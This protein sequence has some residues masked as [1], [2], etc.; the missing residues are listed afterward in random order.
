MRL[1]EPAAVILV[2]LGLVGLPTA[3]LG[4]E[5]LR[6]NSHDGQVINLAGE[7]GAWSQDTIRV[8]QGQKLRLRLTSNDVVHGF[9]LE[10]YGIDIDEVYPGKVQVIEI[11]ADK[12][13]I[14]PFACT[15]LC[16]DDHRSMRGKLIVEPPG[17]S[18]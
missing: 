2:V 8:T 12:A 11:V 6:H 3:A 16:S 7:D 14:F 4:Y 5:S 18:A 1:L 10:G 9:M 17:G 15:V 13:G